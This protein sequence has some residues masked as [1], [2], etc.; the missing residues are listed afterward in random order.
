MY[1][2]DMKQME[3]W[4]LV[5]GIILYICGYKVVIAQK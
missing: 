4:G 5:E 2:I 3:M 1:S